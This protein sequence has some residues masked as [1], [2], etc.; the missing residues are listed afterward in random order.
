MRHR[1]LRELGI[2]LVGV[3]DESDA[4]RGEHADTVDLAPFGE[5]ARD[6][7]FDV[8]CDVYAADVEGA[9][10]AHE[11]ADAAHVISIVRVFIP[12]KGIHIRVK[13]VEKPW[14]T[15]EVLALVASRTE[16][17]CKE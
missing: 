17:L 15:V 12:A 5:V 3:G 6:D 13:S 7:F 4:P 10:L 14:E 8:V 16:A 11:A 2:C 1:F 9:V